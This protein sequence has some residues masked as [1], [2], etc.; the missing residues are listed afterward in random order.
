MATGIVFT[1][2]GRNLIWHRLYTAAPTDTAPTQFEAGTGTTAPAV[3]DVDLDTGLGGAANYTA[4]YPTFD[5]TN[6]QVTARGFIDSATHNGNTIA[7]AG[8]WNT[9]GPDKLVSRAVF[10]GIT[11]TASV[12][13]ALIWK[14]KVL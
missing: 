2:V 11:K 4:G 9:D 7:E 10:T 5:T 8:E 6:H 12:E 1:N 3:T 13:V 14:H